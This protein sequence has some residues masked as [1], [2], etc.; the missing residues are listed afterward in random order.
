MANPKARRYWLAWAVLLLLL[1][2]NLAFTGTALPSLPASAH[3]GIALLQALLLAAVFM[4]L[5][6]GSGLLRLAA[7]AGLFWLLLLFGLTFSDYL[8]RNA[9]V[10]S[11]R[12]VY[13]PVDRPEH[14]GSHRDAGQE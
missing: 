10:A 6:E 3:L 2:V 1:G 12:I 7:G 8:T 14:R 9:D 4:G 5:W 13:T 11:G